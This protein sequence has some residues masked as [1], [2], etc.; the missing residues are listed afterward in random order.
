MAPDD[1]AVADDVELEILRQGRRSLGP[2][3][4]QHPGKEQ[5]KQESYAGKD[6][7][8]MIGICP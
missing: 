3:D 6:T 8:L 4:G 7:G 1:R 2:G 5:R